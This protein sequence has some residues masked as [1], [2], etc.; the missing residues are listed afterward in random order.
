[1]MITDRDLALLNAIARIYPTTKSFLCHW[2]ISR[3]ILAICKRHFGP[4]HPIEEWNN[5][6]KAWGEL[7]K[8]TTIE[9]FEDC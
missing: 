3:N 1:M 7:V 6:M 8:A 2:H 5:F 4:P 9:S